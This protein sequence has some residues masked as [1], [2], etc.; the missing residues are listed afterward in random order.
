METPTIGGVLGDARGSFQRSFKTH[1]AWNAR[2]LAILIAVFLA[3]ACLIVPVAGIAGLGS[4]VGEGAEAPS[5]IALIVVAVV[6]VLLLVVMVVMMA[7]HQGTAY[8]ITLA[9]LSG[10]PIDAGSARRAAWFRLGPLAGAVLLRMLT[11]SIVAVPLVGVVVGVGV[12]SA[13]EPSAGD[14]DSGV[15]VAMRAI[16]AVYALA[17]VWVL[18]MRAFFGLSG[19]V[20]QAEDVGAIAAMRRSVAVLSGHRLRMIGVRVVWAILATLLHLLA[21]APMGLVAAFSEDGGG[22]LLVLLGAPYFV[23]FYFFVLHILSFDSAIEA[24][25]YARLTRGPRVEAVASIFE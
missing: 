1:A 5:A 7:W 19:P 10:E 18:A 14:A 22:E 13:L 4:A 17:F 15:A 23:F 9:D 8:A 25:L 2:F 20:A 24:A 3:A 21:Y 6:Y 16:F 11:D 12:V